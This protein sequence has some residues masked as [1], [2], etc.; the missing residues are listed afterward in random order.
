MGWVKITEPIMVPSLEHYDE[1]SAKRFTDIPITRLIDNRR[2][3]IEARMDEMCMKNPARVI[4]VG[5]EEVGYPFYQGVPDDMHS[6]SAYH[7]QNKYVILED[8][9]DSCFEVMMEVVLCR[10]V[11]CRPLADC[12]GS[13]MFITGLLRFLGVKAYEVFGVVY[14]DSELLGGHG[15][16]IAELEDGKWHLIES[17]LDTAPGYPYGYPII[18]PDVNKWRVGHLVYE[19]WIRFNESELYVWNDDGGE[20]RVYELKDYARFSRREKE[21]RRKYHEIQKAWG[22]DVKPVKESKKNIANRIFSK[23]R[24]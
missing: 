20:N 3:W 7:D 16:V 15:Y 14:R 1:K 9:W 5:I 19:G 22:I 18:N 23:L 21:T 11:G 17:T 13:S 6:W 8:Y 12:D 10:R 4:K 24:W 2:G